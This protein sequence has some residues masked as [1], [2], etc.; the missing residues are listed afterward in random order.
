MAFQVR[1][2]EEV[3]SLAS[4]MAEFGDK[5]CEAVK[6]NERINIDLS[7]NPNSPGDEFF[8]KLKTD[9]GEIVVRTIKEREKAQAIPQ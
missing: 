6:A 3:E 8:A 4:I 5:V 1:R 9:K 2:K 7:H